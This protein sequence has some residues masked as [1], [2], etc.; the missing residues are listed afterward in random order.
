MN[1]NAG[2][3]DGVIALPKGGGA[4][5]GIGEK[6]SPDLHTGTG[7]F[8]VPIALPPG[9]NGLQP[10]LSLV[11]SSGNGNGEYGLG[12][13]LSVPGVSRKTSKGIPRYNDFQDVFI[14]SGA[15][16][17]VPVPGGPVG[18]I[19]YRPRTE[20][21]F[22]RIDHH[23]DASN[24][25]WEVHSKDGLVS[26]YGTPAAMGADPAVVADPVDRTKVFAW[27]LTQTQDPF[28]NQIL[29]EYER[30]T[31]EDG[32]HHWDQLYLKR[33]RYV[34]YQDAG[35]TKF[36]VSI[37][38]EYDNR[39]DPFSEYRSG[40][41]IRTRKRCSR[42][43]V[44]TH[45]EEDRLVRLYHLVYLDQ[46]AEMNHLRPLNGVSVLNQIK[47]VGHDGD[48]I[49]ELPP[50][51][52]GYTSF[53]PQ[54]RDFF[55][56]EGA[57]LPPR[58][59]ADPNMELIDL[60]G[61]GLPDVLEMNGTV[62]YWRNCG[63]G[64]FDLPREMKDAPAG[65]QLSDS[66][67]QLIDADGDGRTDL[68]VSTETLSGYYPLRFGGLWD[69]RSFQR[70]RRAP[71][72][73]LEDPEVRLLDLDGDGVTDAVR[74]GTR[75]ECFFNDPKHGWNAARLVERRA[76]E[77]F[78]N[79]NFSDPRVRWADVTGDGL[80]DIVLVYDG[81][82]EYWPNLG[83][84]RWGK[85]IS[86]QNCP[87][88]PYGYDP[89]RILIGDV[90][91]DGAADLVYV[92][93]GKVLLWIN[94]SG[95]SWSDP[96]EIQGTPPVSDVD[97]VRL[98]DVLGT[99]ISGVLWSTDVNGLSRQNLFFLDFTGGI[100]PYLLDEMDNHM[101]ALT[102]VQYKSSTNFYLEDQSGPETRWKTPLPFPV[103]VVA[104]VEV[105]D[106]ISKGKL[107]TEYCYHHG[108]WDGA[109][110]EFRGF[111]MV[112]QFDTETFNDYVGRGL[113]EDAKSFAP[114][115]PVHFSPPTLVRTWFHQGPIGDEFGDWEELDHSD[116]YWSG[117]PQLLNHTQSVNAFLKT[118]T[119]RRVKRDA[120]RALR[121]SILRT[122][123]YAQDG[124]PRAAR[125]Y[126]V[127]ESC[128]GLR[129]ESP[130]GLDDEERLHL[131]F[132]HL[133]SQRTTQWERG[134]DPMTQFTFTDDYDEFGQPQRQTK[135]ACPRGWRDL[136]DQ[137]GEP[138]LGTRTVT[139]YAKPVEPQVQTRDRVAKTTTS[140]LENTTGKR[141]FDLA[142]LS[143][144]S[145]DLKIIGQMLNFYDGDAFVGLPFGQLGKHG[146]LVK[147]ESLVLTD[148]ILS[149]AY[150]GELPPYLIHDG[151]VVWTEDYPQ[152]FRDQMPA[153]T[154]YTFHSSSPY[155]SGFYAVTERR[156][157]D[158]HGN[159]NGSGKGLVNVIRDPLG[160]D[161]TIGYDQ[162]YQVLPE[163][164]TDAVGLK[165]HV[166]YDY[167]VLQPGRVTDPN[168]NHTEFTFTPLGLLETT[169]VKGKAGEGDQQQPSV[170]MDYDFRAFEESSPD[171]RQPIFVHTGR[172]VHHDTETDVPL[173]QRD[174]AIETVEYSDGFGRLLQTRTQSEEVR[175]GDQSFGGGESVLPA[176][177]S[178]GP[179]GDA[180]GTENTDSANPNVV[181]SGWQTYDNKGNVV[182]KYEPFFSEGWDY[183]QPQDQQLGQK[184]T[185]FYDPR[186]QL[187]R[188]LNP[189]GSEQRVVY[190]VPDDLNDPKQFE[191][192]PWEVYSYDDNDNAGRTHPTIA[193]AYRHHWNTPSN[194][195]IDALG[196]TVLATECNRAK[197]DN[198]DDPLPPIEEYGT[199]STYDIRG[200]LLVV[201]DALGRDAFKQTYDLANR[202]LRIESIDAGIRRT[203]LDAAGNE[204]EKRDSKGALILR[205]HDQLNRPTHLWARDGTGQLL[206]LRERLLYGDNPD[207]ELSPA[208]IAQANL[209]GRLYQH[210]DEAGLL[211]FDAYD[212]KGNLLD[213]SR[214]VISDTAIL[215]VFDSPPPDWQINAFRVGWDFPSATLLEPP[216]AV[217]TTTFAYDALNRME[218][219]QYP[220][221][222]D[223]ERQLLRAHYNRAGALERVEL[224][225]AV[226][227]EHIA[228]NAKGQRT[229]IAYGN[230]VMTRHAYNRETF[231]LARMRTE[232]YS[233]PNRLTYHATGG[234]LQDFAY[235][236]D[237]AGNIT[238]IRDRTPG[239][240]I[241]NS[242][243]GTDALD[244]TFTYDPLY[245]LL[246]ATGREC[247]QSPPNPPWDDTPRCQDG[248]L[249]RA[250]KETYE[251]DRMGNIMH[252]GHLEGAGGFNRNFAL[253][254]ESNRLAV[255]TVG[256]TSFDYT[257]DVNGNLVRETIS[258]HFEWDHSDRMR[259]YRT[260]PGNA[261][262]SVHTHYLYD[263][264]GQRV[265]KL[266]RKQGGQVEVLISIDGVFEHHRIVQGSDTHENDTLH[267]MDNQTRIAMLRV[268]A[269]FPDDST[270]AVKFHLAD[271]LGSS[272]VVIDGSGVFINHEEYTPYGETSFG[273]FARKRY[274]FTSKERDEESGLYY[275]GARYYAAWLGRWTSCDP[276]GI[277]DAI[278]LFLYAGGSPCVFRDTTGTQ[279]SPTQR[280]IDINNQRQDP[281][282]AEKLKL[283]VNLRPPRR[284]RVS[285]TGAAGGTGGKT[286]A[287]GA[288]D[289]NQAPSQIS[290]TG[291]AGGTGDKTGAPG[292]PDPNQAAS[293]GESSGTGTAGTGG[294]GS[295]KS[296]ALDRAA[297]LAG[298]ANLQT[299]D[300]EG[301][302]GGIPG[303]T[304]SKENANA[305][306]QI[307]FIA[308]SLQAVKNI[309]KG[310]WSLGK[311]AAGAIASAWRTIV[312]RIAADRT[313][314]EAAKG[315]AK[316]LVEAEA[317]SLTEGIRALTP[318][319]REMYRKM[320][321]AGYKP[322]QA[323]E[324]ARGIDDMPGL[325]AEFGPNARG[326]TRGFRD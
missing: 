241:P 233:K 292:A 208:Q 227:V 322:E 177:Q 33:I 201:N 107:T 53:E 257:Y 89:K 123:L 48:R 62:R 191:P 182:E 126:T 289:P 102:R 134:D 274:R 307:A 130:L 186:G 287:P 226:Y 90:D 155:E 271:H 70:Y 121:G 114:V 175:F 224:S 236:Y 260:Q 96:I 277:E 99:G 22:A 27:K 179:G 30:D 137:P 14:V 301:V 296:T 318:K 56:L 35:Q 12:W 116:E 288:P 261:E 299:T 324:A 93:H 50:L 57:D 270:P 309:F 203:V 290:G 69:R 217:Y 230:G 17:L 169:S 139:V 42:L 125:P 197:S 146:A 73:D 5:R 284:P 87:R 216:S 278:N 244:R 234:L 54:R 145:A 162:P 15:E 317:K 283:L 133:K 23:S 180:I 293:Q 91:G 128:Y 80:Q 256:A 195:K 124:S 172:R 325:G 9:R 206:S 140:E 239:S 202:R 215:E 156:R 29:Y 52:F 245:R 88:F 76:I 275:Y 220:M 291:A 198:P 196:R 36:L 207:V 143:D 85:R 259:V 279:R 110:R 142:N 92:D 194:A 268:G 161:T 272:N 219:M 19:R 136:N 305:P 26:L 285:G 147:T 326:R 66:G 153:Q 18:V 247:D 141:V 112:E 79:V 209:R 228:Y 255:V 266:V 68:L 46:R 122:E 173:P 71:S 210:F 254:P 24:D 8:T 148:E 135:I 297:E 280:E 131:F 312:G 41:E 47:V 314:R 237:L 13:N 238:S 159:A 164:V 178:D 176:K 44:R 108:Y 61:N 120:L 75:L 31:G 6:F 286:R 181:V 51:E 7:N 231:H 232:R 167:R 221:A 158:F 188:T 204:I 302:S 58:S 34:D 25:Y 63:N 304:G 82:I 262:P 165:T 214:R 310:L 83:H 11:Y 98:A 49:E 225:D 4:L 127:T 16:D 308:M 166:K 95:N 77:E 205:R 187:I 306:V 163:E 151:N 10:Q 20:G 250:Y 105:I 218:T 213:K 149:E 100:K 171:D 281:L 94:R 300:K 315:S 119:D 321:E 59:L 45:A 222:T 152:G 269:S 104:R 160:R 60:I 193:A 229:L 113:H 106:E 3:A 265:K 72:F 101:G 115:A 138:Y 154:G 64:K 200:N 223:G 78:P 38:F 264:R 65:L 184:A 190:G 109:E 294:A 55:P 248:T 174:E 303:G 253:V 81:N 249:T 323:L 251:Y 43:E 144:M 276:V 1:K 37:T 132:P 211:I 313:L 168:D 170:V 242:L 117:D 84:G 32:P 243:L 199:I 21:L 157:Y 258:R 118:L 183:A 2:G 240:G 150:G 273:S 316:L 28:D 246:S 263:A 86:M 319:A 267:V 192:S 129:E 235:E 212:F 111:G 298:L 252:L 74:S 67:V 40:F 97:A 103:Q 311:A 185:M 189:D 39:P 282:S 295:S 320:V